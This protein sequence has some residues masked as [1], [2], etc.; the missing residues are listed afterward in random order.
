M[1]EADAYN[2]WPMVQALGDRLVCAYSRGR[3][4]TIH[5]GERGVFARTSADGGRTWTP[6]VPD[7]VDPAYG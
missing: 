4:H 1:Q 3:R 6:E 5:E 7:A 2:S